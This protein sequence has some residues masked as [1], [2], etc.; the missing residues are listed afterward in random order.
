MCVIEGVLDV[1]EVLNVFVHVIEGVL[2]H[3]SYQRVL[4]TESVV[5][6]IKGVLKV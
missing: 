5:R 1:K 4:K 6:V 3:A 2:C